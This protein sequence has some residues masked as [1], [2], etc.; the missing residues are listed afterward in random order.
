MSNNRYIYQTR[1][2]KKKP[3]HRHVVEEF[4]GRDL[5]HHEHVYHRNG[6]S[7]DNRLENLIIINKNYRRESQ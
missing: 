7:R 6:D 5:E 3:V 1:N 4:L 2:G